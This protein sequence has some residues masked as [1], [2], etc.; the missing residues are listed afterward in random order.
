MVVVCCVFLTGFFVLYSQSSSS[1]I[2]GG[3]QKGQGQSLHPNAAG[4]GNGP[5]GAVQVRPDETEVLDPGRAAAC[6]AAATEASASSKLYSVVFDIGSTGSRVHV[7]RLRRKGSRECAGSGTERQATHTQSGLAD[8]SCL[9][10]EDELFMENHDALSKMADDLPRCVASLEPLYQAALAYVPAAQQRCTPVE[11]LATAG[12]RKLG[13][14]RAGRILTAVEEHFQRGAFWLRGG[15][16]SCRILEGDEE[17]PMA[18]ITVNF[19][20]GRF[21]VLHEPTAAIVDLGGGSTQIVFEPPVTSPSA[22]HMHSSFV[23]ERVLGRRKVRAYQ[24]SYNLGLH[25]AAQALLRQISAAPGSQT[26][27]SNPTDFEKRIKAR[28]AMPCF[29]PGYT[30]AATTVSNTDTGSTAADFDACVR[31]FEKV[32]L[33]PNGAEECPN[34][35]CGIGEVYQPPLQDFTGPF[36]AF[37]YIYDI[38]ARYLPLPPAGSGSSSGGSS[39]GAVLSLQAMAAAG[40]ER[41]HTL[42]MEQVE[43]M[44]ADPSHND[45]L[46]PGFECLYHAYIYALLVH[47]Y[48]VEEHRELHIAKKINGYETAWALGAGLTTLSKL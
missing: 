43:A 31:L 2:L 35:H 37:S 30:D 28:T 47:G 25:E 6:R 44:K 20:L 8:V 19:L 42:T 21:A 13:A 9:E 46:N 16:A 7:F 12:L 41:C 39:G 38:Y 33:H 26:G 17:G 14:E 36:F 27:R 29:P 5:A 23:F 4:A 32:V 34:E 48:G 3:V 10:L 18:W 45:T 24:H 22:S 1:S 11:F 15:K 40:R